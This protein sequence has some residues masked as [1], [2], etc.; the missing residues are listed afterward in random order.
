MWYMVSKTKALSVVV[1]NKNPYYTRKNAGVNWWSVNS[2]LTASIEQI[3]T[4]ENDN[5]IIYYIDDVI[6]RTKTGCGF[7]RVLE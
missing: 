4:I 6:T 5:D 2:T 3:S 7:S 1:D